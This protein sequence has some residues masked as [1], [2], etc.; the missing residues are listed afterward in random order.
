MGQSFGETLRKARDVRSLSTT[1]TAR[2]ARISPAYL[3]RLEN[4]TVKR[5]SPEVL[6]TLSETL[7]VP[8]ADLMILAG[9]KVPGI[10]PLPDRSRIGAA[11]FA[12]L[13]EDEQEELVE[14]LA[15][16]RSRKR[17]RASRRPT[18]DGR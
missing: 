12:D 4:D 11:L 1:E 16:Y 3:N 17:A 2:R 7:A 18:P 13:T 9:Y 14:Y 15:W 5:P 10:E 8:Y 6:H